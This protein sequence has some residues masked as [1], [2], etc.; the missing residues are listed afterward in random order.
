MAQGTSA[1][2]FTP[3][4]RL[5]ETFVTVVDTASMVAAAQ[6]LR[7]TQP[8]VSKT[9]GQLEKQ[10]G[11]LLVDRSQRP[12]RPT[13]A[14][15]LLYRRAI[16]LLQEA[17]SIPSLLGMATNDTMPQIRIG[18]VESFTATG[19]P[20]V[21]ALQGM[22]QEVRISCSLTPE[23]ARRLRQWDLDFVI[24]SDLME[25]E[26]AL[27]R[28]VLLEEP[29]ILALPRTQ[30]A[31]PDAD[32]LRRLPATLPFIRYT[33]RSMIGRTID[34]YLSRARV[35]TSNT[36]EFDTST[37]L[38]HMVTAGLG[39]AVTTPL[40]LLQSR[41]DRSQLNISALPGG[42]TRKLYLVHREGDLGELPERIFQL[43]TAS[44]ANVLTSSFGPAD[45]RISELLAFGTFDR[46]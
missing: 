12:L 39:W 19:A 26:V 16:S 21:K 41:A 7:L 46:D 9:I 42:P 29:F 5:L 31:V 27:V 22:A 6:Q 33:N 1:Y 36:L 17:Q 28:H 11:A 25:D 34:R 23:L 8:A 2:G 20:F 14:G 24:T 13:R 40:C 18:L 32:A 37:P 10:L 43:A 4:L 44:L 30:S 35:S 3:D 15:Q 45:K 38:L